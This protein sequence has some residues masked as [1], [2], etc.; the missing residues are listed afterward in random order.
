MELL[1]KLRTRLKDNP[2]F[3]VF[4]YQG[5]VYARYTRPYR[6]FKVIDLEGLS[7]SLPVTEPG[8]VF[9]LTKENLKYLQEIPNQQGAGE[10]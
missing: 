8:R 5:E 2:N 3:E 4:Q 1:E 10:S 6:F 9:R 7:K